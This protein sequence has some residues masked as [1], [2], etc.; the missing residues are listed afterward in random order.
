M[1][2][3]TGKLILLILAA[4]LLLSQTA[5][6][7]ETGAGEA[8]GEELTVNES[9][10]TDIQYVLYL[11]TNDKDTNTPVFSREEAL[12]QAKDI[13]I[14]HFGG[15]TIQEAHGGWIDNDTEYQEYTMVIYLSDTTLDKIHAAADEMIEVF[16]QSSVLI[17]ANPTRTEFYSSGN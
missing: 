2:K 14:R 11:G 6:A 4:A 1:K 8:F 10:W 17:Q 7:E 5:W 12:E 9:A 13:L 15:Y 3:W 16:R